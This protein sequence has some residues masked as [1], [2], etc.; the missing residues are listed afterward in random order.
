MET[1]DSPGPDSRASKK[2]W[3]TT[4]VP[5]VFNS[6]SIQQIAE[7]CRTNTDNHLCVLLYISN[8]QLAHSD[9]ATLGFIVKKYHIGP[10]THAVLAAKRKTAASE[11]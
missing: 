3:V 8:E 10:S 2:V 1:D 11:S 4:C 9:A 7:S 5:N 6:K